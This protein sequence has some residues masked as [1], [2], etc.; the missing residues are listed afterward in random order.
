MRTSELAAQPHDA[1]LNQARPLEDYNPFDGDVPLQEAVERE[2]AAWA[3][4]EIREFA[5]LCGTAHALELGRLANEHEPILK[6][7]DRFGNRVDVVEFHPS[8]HELMSVGIAAGVHSSPWSAPKPGAHVARAAISH[9]RHQVEQGTSCPLTMTFAVVPSLRMQPEIA[10]EWEPKVLSTVYDPRFLPV[11]QKRGALFGMAMTE[12]QGGSDVR[13]NTSRATP[14][15]SGGP[16]AEYLLEGHKWFCSAPMCDAFLVLAYAEQ[17]LS[18]FLVPRFRPDGT[19]NT[20]RF[21]RLKPKLGNRSNASSE[22]EFRGAWARM[23][24][25]P[26]RG[27]ATILEMVRH[28][29]LDCTLGGASLIRRCVAEATHHTAHRWAFSRPLIQQPLMRNV[30]ADL[31]LESEAATAI[32]FR[33][34]SLFDQA[35]TDPAAAALARGLTPIAKYWVTKRET[36]VA[37]EALECLGGNGFIEESPMPRLFRESPLNSVWEGAGNVQCLDFLR[38]AK[39]EPESIQAVFEFLGRSRGSDPAYDRVLAE[40]IAV[41][42]DAEHIEMRARKVVEDLA[43]LIQGALLM[44]NAPEAVSSAFIRSRLGGEHGSALGTLPADV[45]FDSV[46][47]RAVPIA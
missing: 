39:R 45:A 32:A 29:R 40:T 36:V 16:G 3:T 4:E 24:G 7:H 31:A 19:Q 15:G 18:C 8:Y 25:E 13:A 17:G 46:I 42:G 14:I 28:T 35:D 30:L 22:I 12:R 44:E 6:T 10:A 47:E 2:G 38:A 1:V 37:R 27:I 20:L 11:S 5:T 9:V 43:L 41:A 26:G 21:L 34:A 23:V 33:L